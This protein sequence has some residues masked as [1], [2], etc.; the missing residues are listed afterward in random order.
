MNL[1]Y[2]AVLPDKIIS[3][4][5]LAMKMHFKKEF[6]TY[7]ALKSPAHIT[8]QMPF[9]RLESF[10]KNLIC[11]LY[12]FAAQENSFTLGL[13]GYGHFDK[14]VIF[15]Q[16]EEAPQLRAL[17]ERL[18]LTLRSELGFSNA[19]LVFKFH[20]HIT[21]ATRDI[22]RENFSKAWIICKNKKYTANFDVKCI[23][24]LR[25]QGQFWNVIETFPFQGINKPGC[26]EK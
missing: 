15:V 1:Y 16:V 20:P 3:E 23:S 12:N 5:I 18:S 8:L 24:L 7:H 17:K 25:H 19:E 6:N 13:N 11:C 9:K 2:I 22:S 21:L 14:K 4:D 10:E 26:Q